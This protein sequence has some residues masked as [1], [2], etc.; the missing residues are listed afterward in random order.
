MCV[1]VAPALCLGR[2]GGG[3]N[4][5]GLWSRYIYIYTYIYIY[6]YIHIY[7]YIYIY[8]YIHT[9]I[10]YIYLNIYIYIYT[11]RLRFFSLWVLTRVLGHLRDGSR[12][13]LRGGVHLRGEGYCVVSA[14]TFL[15]PPAWWLSPAW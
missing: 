10:Y 1:P 2:V 9:Y 5:W 15:D 14:M 8:I 7:I 6:I 3:G 13:S 12:K 11:F 4:W